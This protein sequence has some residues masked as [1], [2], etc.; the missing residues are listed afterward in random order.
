MVRRNLARRL[1]RLEDVM[2]PAVADPRRTRK[3]AT[4][5]AGRTGRALFRAYVRNRRDA[6]NSPSFSRQYHQTFAAPWRRVQS[7]SGN[8]K[9]NGSPNA[10]RIPG[11]HAGICSAAA[12]DLRSS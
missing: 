3:A 1:A 8:A 9:T 7:Q 10:P 5:T 11:A 4:A 6:P 2:A 12:D